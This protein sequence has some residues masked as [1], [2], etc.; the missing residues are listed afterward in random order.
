MTKHK[1]ELGDRMKAYEAIATGATLDKRL[2]IYARI[3]GRCFSKFTKGMNRPY[4]SRMMEVMRNTLSDLIEE[5]NAIIGYTQSD[6]ISLLWHHEK[7]ETE[8]FFGGKVFK[9]TSIL[10]S[11][12]TSLFIKNLSCEFSDYGNEESSEYTTLIRRLPHF[13][14]RVFQLHNKLEATNAFIWRLLD[15]RKNAISMV[16]Q[17]Y[18][19][20][21]ELQN[22]NQADMRQMLR[23]FHGI[24]FYED[25][26]FKFIWGS[27]A[28]REAYYINNDVKRHRIKLF[29]MPNLHQRPD[30]VDLIYGNKCDIDEL[31]KID[32]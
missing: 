20:H 27:F 3:D 28:R 26:C 1:D 17:H 32:A 10:A 13:D 12:T 2:P 7:E 25:Y 16:A 6:E 15:C 31:K 21:K 23:D 4:D 19:S 8:A 30:K 18:F 29:T 22:K 14:C 24:D 9:L 11:L 5:T